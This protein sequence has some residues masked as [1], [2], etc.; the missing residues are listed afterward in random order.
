[1]K[2]LFLSIAVLSAL[3]FSSVAQ[4]AQR[5]SSQEQAAM[6][7]E[8]KTDKELANATKMLSLDASQQTKF[9]QYALDKNNAIYALKT[10]AKGADKTTQDGLK[11]QAQAVREKFFTNV[12]TFLTP[13][14]QTKFADVIKSKEETNHTH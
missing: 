10:K 3:S 9:K 8:Q 13:E 2:K 12:K 4:D 7:P 1:M 11:T 5:K 14:Q 6:T